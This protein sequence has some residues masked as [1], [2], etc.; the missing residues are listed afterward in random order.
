[1]QPRGSESTQCS[2]GLCITLYFVS[3]MHHT[4]AH[5]GSHMR[6]A[7]NIRSTQPHATGKLMI[8]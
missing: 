6:T 3:M 1:M 8:C 2:S 4:F 5:I 7:F